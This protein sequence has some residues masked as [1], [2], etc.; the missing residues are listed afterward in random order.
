MDDGGF[1]TGEDRELVVSVGEGDGDGVGVG[2]GVGVGAGGV[3]VTVEERKAV[4]ILPHDD[5]V[6]N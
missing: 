2:V 1:D 3:I 4:T 6:R 5:C